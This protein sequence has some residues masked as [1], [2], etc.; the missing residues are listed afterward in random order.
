[1]SPIASTPVEVMI[2]GRRRET[3]V[4]GAGYE[5]VTGNS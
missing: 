1:M 5:P 3:P 4:L 2:S